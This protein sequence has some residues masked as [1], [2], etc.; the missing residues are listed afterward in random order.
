MVALLECTVN[1]GPFPKILTLIL[2]L[3]CFKLEVLMVG[4]SEL[5]TVVVALSYGPL[6]HSILNLSSVL[7]QEILE[8]GVL[9]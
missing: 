4:P 7:A 8:W 5:K 1:F 2:N 9:E 6:L 3:C